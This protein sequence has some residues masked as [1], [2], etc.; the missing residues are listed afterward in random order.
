MNHRKLHQARTGRLL[1]G[2]TVVLSTREIRTQLG[3]L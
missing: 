2:H 1:A 3:T